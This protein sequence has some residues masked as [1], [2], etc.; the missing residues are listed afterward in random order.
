MFT[1]IKKQ[2]SLEYVDNKNKHTKLSLQQTSEAEE[3][4]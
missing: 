4:S 3:I 1:N 2:I